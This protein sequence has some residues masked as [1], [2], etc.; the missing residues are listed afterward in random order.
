MG[1]VDIAGSP[2]YL[3]P[4]VAVTALLRR[5]LRRKYAEKCED[6]CTFGEVAEWLKA[7]D[8]KSGIPET[9]SGVRI[10]SSPNSSLAPDLMAFCR[11]GLPV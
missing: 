4:V 3:S 2:R 1:V 10:P 9:V 5:F 6:A 8:S 7:P 11:H